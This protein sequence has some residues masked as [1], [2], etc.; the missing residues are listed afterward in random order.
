MRKNIDIVGS[1]L[2]LANFCYEKVFHQK[3]GDETKSFMKN[4]SYLFA[5]TFVATVAGFALNI[6]AGRILGPVEYGK[7]ALVQS[8]TMF[9]SIPMLLGFSNAMVKYASERK[10]SNERSAIISTAFILVAILI[11]VSFI[12]CFIFSPLLSSLFS[13][14]NELFLLSL[15]CAVLYTFYTMATSAL[16]GLFRIKTYAIFQPV[17]AVIVLLAFLFLVFV[18]NQVS[19]KSIIYPT[20][21]GYG[22][23]SIILSVFFLRKY[24]KLSID[25]IWSKILSGYSIFA[26]I[27]GLSFVFYT[28]IDKILINKYLAVA[29]VG[30]YRAYFVAS[31]NITVLL[32]AM[33]NTI[34]FPTISKY[35]EKG[36]VFNRINKLIPYLV[37][38]GVPLMFFCEFI[39][40]KLYGKQYPIN[41]VLMFI[42][43][44]AAILVIWYGLYDW[45]FASEGIRGTKISLF[46]TVT[47]AVLNL[48]LNIYLIP[49]FGLYGAIGAHTISFSVGICCLYLLKRKII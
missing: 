35:K 8:V 39:I 4:L 16:K 3:I 47:I 43:A 19:F 38:L 28:N 13:T 1:L 40:L 44:L 6:I 23:T 25:R 5:G 46:G 22:I 7:V 12:L 14:S 37:G 32:W 29:D 26:A 42:F 24:L 41:P 10:D 17:Y 33:F 15:I 18:K 11:L 31:V 9:L 27:G 48:L 30:I 36:L 34:F 2:K 20:F 45:T 21:L 49:R